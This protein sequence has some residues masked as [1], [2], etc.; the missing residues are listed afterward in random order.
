MGER[1]NHKRHILCCEVLGPVA[2]TRCAGTKDGGA[3]RKAAGV[4]EDEDSG[5]T[6][7]EEQGD[8]SGF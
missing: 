4:L 2:G 1:G 6:G 7:A 3:V 5:L 8:S